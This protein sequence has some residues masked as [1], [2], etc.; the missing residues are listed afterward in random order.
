M[1]L[2]VRQVPKEVRTSRKEQLRKSNCRNI[3]DGVR[4]QE[5]PETVADPAP[6]PREGDAWER[7]PRLA[8]RTPV[9]WS[10]LHG[11][12]RR[13]GADRRSPTRDP[14][15][16]QELRP[17]AGL[18]VPRPRDGRSRGSEWYH[19]QED[20]PL[21]A[22]HPLK[23]GGPGTGLDQFEG[24]KDRGV[25]VEDGPRTGH[26]LRIQGELKAHFS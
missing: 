3:G 4:V 6:P 26:R 12:E 1:P 23:D 20:D 17:D 15:N 11:G 8:G 16:L 19:L 13:K 7:V 5:G 2:T 9:N 25:P 10:L 14:A 24:A 21:R 18:H 22:P